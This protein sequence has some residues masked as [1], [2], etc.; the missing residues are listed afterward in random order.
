MLKDV[1]MKAQFLQVC[2]EQSCSRWVS[3]PLPSPPRCGITAQLAVTGRQVNLACFGREAE[4][5]AT[6]RG[7]CFAWEWR[8]TELASQAAEG[9]SLVEIRQPSFG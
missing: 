4:M 2:S 6:K 5:I 8:C 9:E 7:L 1:E 3:R